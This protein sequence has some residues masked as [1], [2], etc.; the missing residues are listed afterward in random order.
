MFRYHKNIYMTIVLFN[1]YNHYE[2]TH[3]LSIDCDCDGWKAQNI[4]FTDHDG[5]G[6]KVT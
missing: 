2:T 4:P 6:V 1:M 5:V 3:T